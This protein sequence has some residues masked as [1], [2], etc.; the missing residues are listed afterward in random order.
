MMLLQRTI[1]GFGQVQQMDVF[2]K[3]QRV[4]VLL[5]VLGVKVETGAGR[6]FRSDYAAEAAAV[7]VAAAAGACL[8]WIR[9]R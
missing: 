5:L 2:Q 7:A 9:F 1:F 6:Q 3:T 8:A 4:S